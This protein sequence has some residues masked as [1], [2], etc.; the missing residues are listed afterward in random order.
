MNTQFDVFISCRKTGNDCQPTRD[1]LIARNVFD[2]LNAH[3]V[4]SFLA[5]ESLLAM[6]QADYKNAIDQVL[7]KVPV[8]VVVACAAENLESPWVKY[9]WDSFH[10]DVL[11]GIKRGVLFSYLDNVDVKLLPRTLRQNQAI[12][13]SEGSLNVLFSYIASALG[14]NRMEQMAEGGQRAV[15]RFSR[16]TEIIAESRLL[17]LE[18]TSGMFGG[19]FTPEQQTRMNNQIESLKKVLEKESDQQPPSRRETERG[20]PKGEL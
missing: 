2:F 14:L 15:D 6:G 3:G 7:D 20:G 17:E 4:R 9:E 10:N 19:M 1:S 12:H 5:E 13:H 8:M 16:M 18:I 11:G